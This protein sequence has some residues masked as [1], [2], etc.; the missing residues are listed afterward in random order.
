MKMKQY[1]FIGNIIPFQKQITKCHSNS[2]KITIRDEIYKKYKE[3][4]CNGI[5]IFALRLRLA[6]EQT[7]FSQ[8]ARKATNMAFHREYRCPV[9]KQG[10][11][12]VVIS[13]QNFCNK[14]VSREEDATFS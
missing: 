7:R 2:N 14:S 4:W 9:I 5:R 10:Q 3:D 8:K 13:L 1:N 11:P 12:L 6:L